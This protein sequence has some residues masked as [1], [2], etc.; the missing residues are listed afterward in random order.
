MRD[1]PDR[2]RIEDVN[3]AVACRDNGIVLITVHGAI[4]IGTSPRCRDATHTVPDRGAGR[5][6]AL[7]R[8]VS[9]ATNS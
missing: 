3:L 4:G 7:A 9:P 2:G 6:G 8:N 1:P 5:I